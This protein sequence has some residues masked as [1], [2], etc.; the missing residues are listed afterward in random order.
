MSV[1]SDINQLDPTAQFLLTDVE[2][3]YQSINNILKTNFTEKIFVPEFGSELENLLFEPMDDLTALA[4]YNN[5]IGAIERWDSR[6]NLDYGLSSVTPIIKDRTYEVILFFTVTG[7][8]DQQ[9]EFK[10]LLK[11]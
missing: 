4:I 1:Y 5:I 2:S 6:V 9:I 7:L 8:T 11:Q 3:V 10:G